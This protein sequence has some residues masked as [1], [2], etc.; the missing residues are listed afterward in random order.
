M[1]K[2]KKIIAFASALVMSFSILSSCSTNNYADPQPIKQLESNKV[3]RLPGIAIWGSSMAYGYYGRGST[4]LSSIDNNMMEN[5]CSIPVANMGVPKESNYTVLARAGATKMLVNSFTIPEGIEKVE[6]K[7][8]GEDKKNIIPLRWGTEW[9]GG[10][11]NVTIAGI[12]GTLSIDSNTATF[13]KP[14]YFFTRSQEGKK[15][16]IKKGEQ[17]I[18]TSMNENKDYVPVICMGDDGGWKSF[19]ELIKQQQALLDTFKDKDKFIIL[20]LFT[21]PLT[22]KQEKSL[23]DDDENGKARAKLVKK[24]NEAYDKAM[25][26]KWGE[27]YVS[28]REY[29]CSNVALDYLEKNEV[30]YKNVDK[31]NMSNGVVPEVLKYDPNLL[32][33]RGYELAGEAVFKK[34]VELGYLY[35]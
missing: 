9:D 27:H 22:E 8:Y 34:M 16:K 7:L 2:V 13:E 3:E 14:T 26:K 5:E 17:I 19:D 31:V 21:V 28:S 10:M 4:I 23:P 20:G 15:V 6:I 25:K 29:L 32:N 12:E 30:D 24:N 11:S 1:N 18:S 33:G 35:N